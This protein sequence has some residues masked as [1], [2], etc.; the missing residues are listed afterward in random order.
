MNLIIGFCFGAMIGW[1]F[2]S[3][4]N[5]KWAGTYTTDSWN[6]NHSE[7]LV[8]NEDGTCERPR[9]ESSPCTYK[10]VG[11]KVYFNDEDRT[12]TTL[13]ETGLVYNDTAFTKLK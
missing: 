10:V 1:P 4:P 12:Y 9:Q 2:E 8:L 3:S 6:G 7:K 13:G 5:S 11:N